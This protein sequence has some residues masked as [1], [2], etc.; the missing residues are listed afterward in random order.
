MFAAEGL[1]WSWFLEAQAM[2][3]AYASANGLASC[4]RLVSCSSLI[5]FVA[6][7]R[8]GNRADG[9]LPELRRFSIQ[10]A[11]K[12]PYIIPLNAFKIPLMTRSHSELSLGSREI[13][14][15][16]RIHFKQELLCVLQVCEDF[17]AVPR[18]FARKV[19]RNVRF[20]IFGIVHHVNGCSKELVRFVLSNWH[21]RIILFFPK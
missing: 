13:W 20:T 5:L 12:R 3:K 10:R 15:R 1:D 11:A 21:F 14:S 19:L 4:R 8:L 9:A 7:E 16:F 18:N 6:G 17:L 2:F